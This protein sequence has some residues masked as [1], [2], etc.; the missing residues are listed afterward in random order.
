MLEK[1]VPFGSVVQIFFILGNK[2]MVI[3]LKFVPL[4]MYRLIS[5]FVFPLAPR[6]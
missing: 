2:L 5:P 3:P 1:Q 4:E 6:S